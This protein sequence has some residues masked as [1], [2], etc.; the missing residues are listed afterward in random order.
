VNIRLISATNK[1]LDDEVRKGTFREDLFYRISVFPIK[2]PSLRERKADIPLLAEHFI[3][4]YSQRERKNVDGIQREALNIL[5]GYHWPGNVRE[6]ENA[7]E[8][9]VVITN[10]PQISVEDLP[11]HI[12]TIGK[13]RIAD[14]AD[15]EDPVETLPKWIEKLEIDVLRKA[16]LEFEGN[17]TKVAKKLGI[18]RAT[19]YRK[20]KKYNLPISR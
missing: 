13:E 7:I 19:I 17:I 11:P 18:G 16:L 8:R 20:A 1:N 12:V 10:L 5:M 14:S 2:L 15:I 4:R 9:A 3:N 6:L